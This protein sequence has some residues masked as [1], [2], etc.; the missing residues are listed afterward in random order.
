[1]NISDHKKTEKKV[2]WPVYGLSNLGRSYV[3]SLNDPEI[4]FLTIMEN[5]QDDELFSSFKSFYDILSKHLKEKYI[6]QLETTIGKVG[7]G[8]WNSKAMNIDEAFLIIGGMIQAWA[9]G[10]A[11][12]SPSFQKKWEKAI[13]EIWENPKARKFIS[14][15]KDDIK[16]RQDQIVVSKKMRES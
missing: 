10:K 1:M 14:L 8:V 6:T 15:T 7:L 11:T 3:L 16:I 2:T 13:I 9:F 4:R 12:K 5:Y